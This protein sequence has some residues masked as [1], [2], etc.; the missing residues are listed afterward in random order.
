VDVQRMANRMG[1]VLL[2]LGVEMEDR[3][4]MVLPDSIEFVATWF[5]VAKIEAVITMVNT[6]V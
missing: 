3:V 6:I 4:L 2:N 5:A 1:N